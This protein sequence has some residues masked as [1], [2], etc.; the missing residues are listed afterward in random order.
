MVDDVTRPLP[1][2]PSE[3]PR[4][5]GCYLFSDAGGTVLYV[6]KAKSL[7][8]RL[9]SYFTA[10]DHPARTR[11][12][13]E[14]A[15]QV[16]WVEVASEEDAF[17]LE[18]TLIRKHQPPF[19]VK[20]KDDRRYPEIALSEEPV[21]RVYVTRS[22]RRGSQRRFGPYRSGPEAKRLLDA[23]L[24]MFPVRTCDRSTYARAERTGTPCILAQ[25]GRCAAPCVGRVDVEEHS[26]LV[27]GLSRF[28]GGA[29][30]GPVTEMERRM[31]EASEQMNFE[32]AAALRDQV[33]AV[34]RATAPLE[35]I[36]P[37][38]GAATAVAVAF[39]G[40]VLACAT[41]VDV[42]E[43]RL[44]G[45]RSWLFDLSGALPGECSQQ[46]ASSLAVEALRQ[47]FK[48]TPPPRTLAVPWELEGAEL[49][50]LL[51]DMDV[52]PR[53]VVPKR[54]RLRALLQ[55]ALRNAEGRLASERARRSRSH[56]DR[57]DQ[58]EQLAAACGLPGVPRRIEGFD[59]SHFGGVGTVGSQVVFLDGSPLP[60][61]YRLFRM[62][63][64]QNDDPASMF[65]LVGRR[66]ARLAAADPA[67]LP[68]PDLVVIDGGPT[69]LDAA[70]RAASAA[71]F[72]DMPMVALA[73]REE[74][75][76]L[77]GAHA[78]LDLPSSSPAVLLARHVRD[79]AHRFAL[80]AQRRSR[81]IAGEMVDG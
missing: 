15:R 74:Q 41:V 44:V 17:Q 5:P 4:S 33:A 36:W 78:P 9:A 51:A 14:T 79:E 48:L 56:H 12:M 21:P 29:I 73:K 62:H 38:G 70:V 1:I 53:V 45:T 50:A 3:I 59:I 57:E 68:P 49:A 28:L 25:L 26:R 75:L 22:P 10:A 64:P 34:R 76:W 63:T 37:S 32:Q 8:P 7:R 16:E 71:G 46:A 13:L 72:E 30:D 60:S 77:P 47:H 31:R 40:E 52:H 20:L 69:Q 6:G 24:P 67:F 42:R 11:R 43:G 2:T 65:E 55:L 39:E 23:A 27:A 18:W 35:V 54:G 66:F 81:S 58:A 19:N 80:S 61:A